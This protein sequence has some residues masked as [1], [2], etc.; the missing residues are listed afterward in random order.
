MFLHTELHRERGVRLAVDDTGAGYSSFAHV[1]RLRPDVIK[2]DRSLLA[3]DA[4]TNFNAFPGA[5]LDDQ[6]ERMLELLRA[7]WCAG[8]PIH[9][10]KESP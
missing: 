4:L 2:M 3:R 7:A 6:V 10:T 9:G 8:P 5:R 1:L